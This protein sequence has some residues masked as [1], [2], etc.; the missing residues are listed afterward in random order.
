MPK[1]KKTVHI[2]VNLSN[3]LSNV[4]FHV[5]QDCVSGAETGEF[6]PGEDGRWT[7]YLGGNTSCGA[8]NSVSFNGGTGDTND[9]DDDDNAPQPGTSGVLTSAGSTANVTIKQEP[10]DDDSDIQ[11]QQP[12][13]DSLTRDHIIYIV[14]LHASDTCCRAKCTCGRRCIVLLH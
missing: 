12:P 7:V 13:Q 3:I 4:T 8:N 6:G 10:T 2:T 1:H 5:Y 9:D 11:I 14:P